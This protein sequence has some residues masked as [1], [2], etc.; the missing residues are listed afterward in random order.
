MGGAVAAAAPLFDARSEDRTFILRIE[1]PDRVER[2]E[3]LWAD[4]SGEPLRKAALSFEVGR[5]PREIERSLAL[6]VGRYDVA[7]TL[8]RDG[9]PETTE[10]T[11]DVIDGAGTIVVTVP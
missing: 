4:A 5:A 8:W 11:I 7:A 1:R 9:R 2:V 6:A 3:M 10:R